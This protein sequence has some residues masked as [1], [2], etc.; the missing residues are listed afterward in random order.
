MKP[1]TR[2]ADPSHP[3]WETSVR[4]AVPDG[5]I[6]ETISTECG[7]RARVLVTEGGP[8]TEWQL[9]FK[10]LEAGP[11]R[12]KFQEQRRA[13][14]SMCRR[15][16]AVHDRPIGKFRRDGFELSPRRRSEGLTKI[17]RA[18]LLSPLRRASKR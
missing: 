14:S 8:K 12:A 6:Y 17:C 7:T 16:V 2:P 9:S 13:V 10:L 11:T 5:P 18:G 3:M 15:V 1:A 4:F